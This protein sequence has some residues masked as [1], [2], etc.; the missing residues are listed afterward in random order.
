MLV[1]LLQPKRHQAMLTVLL[2][3][4]L[5]LEYPRRILLQNTVQVQLP[6]LPLGSSRP[7]L[8]QSAQH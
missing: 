4:L 5:L 3:L 6:A 8:Q 2:L 7:T 1:S